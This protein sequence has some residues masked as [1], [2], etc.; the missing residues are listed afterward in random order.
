MEFSSN[1]LIS[2]ISR[3]SGGI[4]FRILVCV[5]LLGVMDLASNMLCGIIGYLDSGLNL[6]LCG[7]LL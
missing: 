1:N 3:F 7:Y 6:R 4:G 2:N 5:L